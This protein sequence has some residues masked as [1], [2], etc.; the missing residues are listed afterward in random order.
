MNVDERALNICG[1]LWSLFNADGPRSEVSV[2]DVVRKSGYTREVVDTYIKGD[3]DLREIVV[4]G[5]F[6][7]IMREESI[8][9]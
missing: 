8:L 5:G 7:K 4:V 6:S 3:T 9:A 2:D 1:A